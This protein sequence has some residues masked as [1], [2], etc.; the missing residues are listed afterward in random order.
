MPRSAA[1]HFADLEAGAA[2]VNDAKLMVL[3]NGRVG[4]TQLCRWLRSEPYDDSIPS[5]HG[6]LVTSAPLPGGAETR[7]NIWDFGGQDIY[8][9][10]HAL[11]MRTSAL[12]L[13]AWTPQL[14]NTGTF[15]VD[16]I[17]FRNHP[18]AYW[19]DYVRRRP[20]PAARSSSC[21]PAATN[22]RTTPPVRCRKPTCSKPS[23][24]ARSGTSAPGSRAGRPRWRRP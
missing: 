5:T 4:K 23:S 16:G 11:F 24:F 15:V 7:L 18:L 19:V 22:R 3:G 14:E 21:R 6:V 8:H 12:F 20:A 13:L 10:T 17:R 9:G 2:T 1:R